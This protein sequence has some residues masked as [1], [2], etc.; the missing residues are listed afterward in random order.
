MTPRLEESPDFVP[1]PAALALV[2][3]T[4]ALVY[5]LFPLTFRDNVLT[6]AIPEGDPVDHLTDLANLLNLKQIDV[7]RWQS[8]EQITAAIGRSYHRYH[9][10]IRDLIENLQEGDDEPVTLREQPAPRVR[11]VSGAAARAAVP[12]HLAREYTI[13]PLSY[14]DGVLRAAVPAERGSDGRLEDIRRQLGLRDFEAVYWERERIL[15][16]IERWYG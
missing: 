15:A 6:V 14:E 5:H 1:E 7:V 8:R 2:P 3:E 9:E 13:F 11:D 12:E 10:S 16:M 4:M